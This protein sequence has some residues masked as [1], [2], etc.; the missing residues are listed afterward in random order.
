VT[1]LNYGWATKRHENYSPLLHR[2][3]NMAAGNTKTLNE[4][5]CQF[6]KVQGIIFS[7][8]FQEYWWSGTTV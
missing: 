2:K 1:F 7:C 8:S 6:I 4:I 3:S 5:S